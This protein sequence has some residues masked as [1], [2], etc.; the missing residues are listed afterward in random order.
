MREHKEMN[1]TLK[2]FIPIY[3]L[4]KYN[5]RWNRYWVNSLPENNP[6]P[7]ILMIYNSV[8]IAVLLTIIL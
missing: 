8:F 2:D 1:V 3:G 6:G 7:M 5:Q 4:I